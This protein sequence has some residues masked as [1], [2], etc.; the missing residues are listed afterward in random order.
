MEP[1]IFHS[2]RNFS[3]ET[4][5]KVLESGFILPRKMIK[6][7]PTDTNN[8][9]NG[10]DYISVAQK[11]LMSDSMLDYYRSSYNELICGS[12]CAVIT[13]KIDGITYPNYVDFGTIYSEVERERATYHDRTVR[14]SYYMDEL[15]TNVPIP[16]S[17]FLA[18]G[19]PLSYFK[20]QKSESVVEKELEQIEQSLTKNRLNIPIIDS[21][22]YDFAD[23][24]EHI[25]LSKIKRKR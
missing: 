25:A 1:Y 2:F 19:Y 22:S 20:G 18:I 24:K 21:T 15:Q 7:G 8:I 11:T 6:D 23:D 10:N 17:K 5:Y 4:L 14:Y 12:L 3:L 16:T 13:P 9:F